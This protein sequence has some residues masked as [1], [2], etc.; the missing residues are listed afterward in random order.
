MGQKGLKLFLFK[1]LVRD[2]VFQRD[3]MVINCSFFIFLF[4][5][6]FGRREVVLGLKNNFRHGSRHGMI[7]ALSP[8]I[9]LD[10]RWRLAKLLICEV[11][12]VYFMDKIF[13]K[14][15]FLYGNLFS[16]QAKFP[17]KLPS[18]TLWDAHLQ[19]IK[20]LQKTKRGLELVSLP[21]FLHYFWRKIYLTLGFIN[22]PNFI[23]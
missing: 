6:F 5:Y 12:S 21:H 19:H 14:L 18:L 7:T 22:W 9:G 3:Y 8:C 10:K 16:I 11:V 23:A 13:W 15:S 20:L 1:N 17:K 4:I 2:M